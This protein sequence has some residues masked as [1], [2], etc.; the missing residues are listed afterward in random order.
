MVRRHNVPSWAFVCVTILWG[1]VCFTNSVYAQAGL[2]DSLEA[3]DANEDGEISPKEITPLARPYLERI[4]KARRMSLDRDNDID[5]LQE[6]ARIYYALQNGVADE[7]VRAKSDSTV[8]PFGPEKD[9]PLVPDFGL[10]EVKYPYVQADLDEADRTLDR[11]DR[12]KDG[13]IDRAEAARSRWTH[14][15]PFEMDLTI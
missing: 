15:N 5:D 8:L 3:L 11:N 13:F 9:Q 6:A 7:R 4:T 1:S 10:E 12:N 2:R 14:R